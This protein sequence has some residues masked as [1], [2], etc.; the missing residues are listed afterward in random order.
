MNFDYE[1]EEELKKDSTRSEYYGILDQRYKVI[2]RIGDDGGHAFVWKALDS[3]T[4]QIVAIKQFRLDLEHS[5]DRVLRQAMNE[6]YSIQKVDSKN[7]IKLLDQA[8]GYLLMDGEEYYEEWIYLVLEICESKTFFELILDD[9]PFTEQLAAHCFKEL[10]N[11][12]QAIH[13]ADLCHRDIKCE[14]ILIDSSNNLKIAD[15]GYA[16]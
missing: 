13:D 10:L 5:F 4:G 8:S 9:G 12:V 14:N 16:A 11:G 1:Y 7:C 3:L 15:F 6:G 2:E